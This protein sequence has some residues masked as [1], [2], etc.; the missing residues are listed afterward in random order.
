MPAK[1]TA[2]E[3]VYKPPADVKCTTQATSAACNSWPNCP[4]G[5]E[6]K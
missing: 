3:N 6:K 2:Q 4:C 1:P 5:E